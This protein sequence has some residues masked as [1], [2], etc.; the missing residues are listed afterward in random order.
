MRKDLVKM[1]VC[2]VCRAGLELIIV[3]EADGEIT[4]GNLR[5]NAC[6]IDYPIEEGIPDMLPPDFREEA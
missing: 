4:T 2:P 1:L 5:C 3:A 6:K